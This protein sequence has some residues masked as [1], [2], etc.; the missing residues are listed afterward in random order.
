M[1]LCPFA[2]AFLLNP[3][4]AG[5]RFYKKKK[6]VQHYTL[7]YGGTPIMDAF[8][9]DLKVRLPS[10]FVM[11]AKK[12]LCRHR[13]SHFFR[14]ASPPTPASSAIVELRGSCV[15]PVFAD[16]QNY[17]LAHVTRFTRTPEGARG[18]TT[19]RF[20]LIILDVFAEMK[21]ALRRARPIFHPRKSK[22]G[23]LNGS[24]RQ[25]R[26]CDVGTPSWVSGC[27]RC[28]PALGRCFLAE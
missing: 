17:N 4:A 12:R 5:L 26:R 13:A 2:M 19:G 27:L 14:L 18:Q 8:L 21:A 23:G 10:R 20:R 24:R 6:V 16:G 7:R 11:A 3:K 28:L 1:E 25:I 22:T 15:L 9:L